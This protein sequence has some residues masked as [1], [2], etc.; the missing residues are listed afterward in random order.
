MLDYVTSFA[1]ALLTPTCSTLWL[2]G[3]DLFIAMTLEIL[4]LTSLFSLDCLMATQ[5]N[6]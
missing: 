1:S 4:K 2:H 3:A 5:K 6:E